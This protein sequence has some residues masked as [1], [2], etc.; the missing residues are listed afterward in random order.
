MTLPQ[1]DLRIASRT[2]AVSDET[3]AGRSMPFV[4][5]S[6]LAR[7]RSVSPDDGSARNVRD[8]GVT[9]P[10][11]P[12]AVWAQA[13]ARGTVALMSS[14]PVKVT[15]GWGMWGPLPPRDC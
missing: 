7:C 9:T 5:V 13:G 12:R 15:P 8:P 11:S 1:K 10:R 6:P 4:Q 3:G 2:Y 14:D